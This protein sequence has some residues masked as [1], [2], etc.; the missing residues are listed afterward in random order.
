MY[1]QGD[2]G[3]RCAKIVAHDPD[4][5]RYAMSSAVWCCRPATR[6]TVGDSTRPVDALNVI[7]FYCDAHAPVE[8]VGIPT[9]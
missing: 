4:L 9:K 5:L 2:Y 6:A 1:H 8:A 3:V 7:H